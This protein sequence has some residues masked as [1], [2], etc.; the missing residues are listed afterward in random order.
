MGGVEL[1]PERRVF[2]VVVPDRTR[3]SLFPLIKKHI[4]NRKDVFIG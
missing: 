2:A 3:E 1:T 4:A